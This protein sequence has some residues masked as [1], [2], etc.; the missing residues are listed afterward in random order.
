MRSPVI[1]C[2][3]GNGAKWVICIGGKWSL[4]TNGEVDMTEQLPVHWSPAT[5]DALV[6]VNMEA[7]VS[8]DNVV[9]AGGFG[10]TNDIS[11]S[12]SCAGGFTDME[13]HLQNDQEYGDL[14]GKNSGP[15]TSVEDIPE[16]CEIDFKGNENVGE[17]VTL[18]GDS[19][20]A[21]YME[22]SP[23][24][25]EVLRAGGFG[26]TDDISSFLPVA[27][28]FTDFEAHIRDVEDYEDLEKET[29][30]PGLGWTNDST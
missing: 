1:E 22:T 18:P 10:A 5:R 29:V 9:P 13:A 16:V 14:D 23:T 3:R 15:S 20:E 19:C 28:D 12:V 8:G 26:A 6:K 11:S 21:I 30:R 24:A 17:H 25:D 4:K 27:S 7:P 2:C